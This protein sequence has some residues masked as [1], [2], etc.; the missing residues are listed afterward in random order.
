[1]KRSV[2]VCGVLLL[3]AVSSGQAKRE[4]NYDPVR[5]AKVK[6]AFL[7]LDEEGEVGTG[8][9]A[10]L[11]H[12]FSVQVPFYK[13][14]LVKPAATGRKSIAALVE[15]LRSD[16]TKHNATVAWEKLIGIRRRAVSPLIAA[17]GS[18]DYQQR[19]LAAS[20]LGR[21]KGW[22]VVR[23]LIGQLKDDEVPYNALSA[24]LA[25]LEVGRPALLPLRR[26]V[27]S[28]ADYQQVTFMKCL[29][30]VLEP[31]VKKPG[32]K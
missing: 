6:A 1:M 7:A 32:R 11:L 28:S 30:S 10:P 15:G 25:L 8:N 9:H 14:E 21:I 16:N 31:P 26:A 23:A 18:G 27:R 13:N 19:I 22:K 2:C 3:A 29:I 12:Y 24:Y 4:I 5:V 17:L 20:I